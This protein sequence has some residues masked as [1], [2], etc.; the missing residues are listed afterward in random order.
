MLRDTVRLA[1]LNRRTKEIVVQ[2]VTIKFAIRLETFRSVRTEA[3]DAGFF[4]AD[5]AQSERGN[6][7]T[8]VCD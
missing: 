3:F 1:Q 8:Y 5:K 6:E 4:C 2:K 7:H